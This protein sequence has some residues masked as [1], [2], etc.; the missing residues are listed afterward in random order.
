M[1][2]PLL[3][4]GGEMMRLF[5]LLT[6]LA[7]SWGLANSSFAQST[8]GSEEYSNPCEASP[9]SDFDFWVGEWVAFD[10]DTGIVEG[11]DVIEKVNNGCAIIQNWTQL[12]DRFRDPGAPYRYSGLSFSSV[13]PDGQWQQTWVGNAGNS[14]VNRGSLNDQGTMVLISGEQ[15]F[16][17]AE[18]A[19]TVFERTWFF[20]PQDDGSVH[21]WGEIRNLD[22]EGNWSDPV[23]QWNLNYISRHEAPN[24]VVGGD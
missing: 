2:E 6:V 24:L 12:T 18:G 19:E 20:D 13:L 4:E 1:A 8:D 9:I 7:V 10:Y 23:I 17:N 21:M 22:G 15:T 11:F 16:I 3:E 5:S 14:I